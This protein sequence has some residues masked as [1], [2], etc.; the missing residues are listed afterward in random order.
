MIYHSR[1]RFST[2]PKFNGG[3]LYINP[4]LRMVILGLYAA[5]RPW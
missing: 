3:E 4:A 2:A 1:E 5:A